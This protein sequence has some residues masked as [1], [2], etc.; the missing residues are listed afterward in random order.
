MVTRELEPCLLSA[1][2]V[3]NDIISG[4]LKNAVKFPRPLKGQIFK[5]DGGLVWGMPS[6][7]SQFMSFWFTYVL[8]MYILN[9]PRGRLSVREKF[10]YSAAGAVVVSLVVASRIVFEYHNWNQVVVGLFLGSVLAA[11]YYLLVS[12]LREY[13]VL[14]SILKTRLFRWWGMKDSFGRGQFATL[15]EE[16]EKWEREVGVE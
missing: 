11:C 16:R 1:G 3:C 5:Q 15:G 9:Y 8:F 13:G 7:H 6:S 10:V 4:L 12:L 2:H 14:D